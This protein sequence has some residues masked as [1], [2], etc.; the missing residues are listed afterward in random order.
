MSKT[1]EEVLQEVGG[2]EE[3]T[4]FLVEDLDTAAEAQRRI[5]YFHDEMAEI[6]AVVEKQIQPW[7]DKIERIKQWGEDAKAEH[8]NKVQ[9]YEQ[10][11]NYYIN[12]VVQKQ[13]DAGKKPKKTIKLPYG[14]IKLQ[15]QQP[16]F[17]KDDEQLLAHA[18]ELGYVKVKEST[19]WAELK[20][21]AHIKDGRMYDMNGELIPGVE[22]KER[23]DKFV[24]KLD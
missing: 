24:H 2:E 16:E 5:A 18:R 20:K 19:D 17:I 3:F 12:E 7:L 1:L 8:L 22:V 13:I 21:H 9:H 6:D 10:L 4:P 23:E 11:L 15:K 14:Q